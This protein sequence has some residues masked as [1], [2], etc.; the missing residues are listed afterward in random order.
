MQE[1]NYYIPCWLKA[2]TIPFHLARN[3][4]CSLTL[5]FFFLCILCMYKYN[6]SEEYRDLA[7]SALHRSIA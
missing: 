6:I 4:Q 2:L 1:V 5:S 7:G 3:K